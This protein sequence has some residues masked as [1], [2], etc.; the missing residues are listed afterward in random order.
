MWS[1][2]VVV[3]TLYF[4]TLCL[5]PMAPGAHS[6]LSYRQ[7]DATVLLLLLPCLVS[8]YIVDLKGLRLEIRE[9]DI[10]HSSKYFA[11]LTRGNT[12]RMALVR[13]SKP[14]PAFFATSITKTRGYFGCG[15]HTQP[16]PLTPPC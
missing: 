4:V 12:S 14:L 7:L 9:G 13:L 3:L 15:T 16:H 5:P 10:A 11:L 6:L 2:G 8:V 1:C